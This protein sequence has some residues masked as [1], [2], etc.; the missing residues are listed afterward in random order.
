VASERQ[1]AANR[2]NAQKSTGPRSVAGKQ[3]A[4]RNA[5]RHG[6]AG[7]VRQLGKFSL[8]IETLAH[9]IAGAAAASAS[10][11]I[12]SEVLEFARAAAR[13]ELELALIRSKKAATISALVA[14]TT[15][16]VMAVSSDPEVNPLLAI[17]R[18]GAP[19]VELLLEQM[20]PQLASQTEAMR[21]LLTDIRNLD[22]Y[23][24]RAIG[25][26]DRAVLQIIARN[27]LIS[28]DKM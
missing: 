8:S 1:I 21:S 2:R 27:F 4:S 3:R 20:A 7:G 9:Q 6:L 17:S 15:S 14:A 11:A 18:R 23:E 12:D 16:Q 13:A 5:Y 22:R 26:R 10:A 19:F 24:R 25:R 28:N